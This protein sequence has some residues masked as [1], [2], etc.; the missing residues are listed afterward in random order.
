MDKLITWVLVVVGVLVPLWSV[1][2]ANH[3]FIG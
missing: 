1:L 3:L 2:T